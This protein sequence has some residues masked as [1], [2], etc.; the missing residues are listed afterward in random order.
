MK[1]KPKYTIE[2]LR[3]TGW[4]VAVLH[5][6]DV[7]HDNDGIQTKDAKMT[8]IIITNT[9]G[10]HAQGFSL[11]HP[12]DNYNRKLGNT[13]ALGRAMKNMLDGKHCT[14]PYFNNP[15]Q[16]TLTNK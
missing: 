3:K 8:H 16:T 6:S 4:K 11:S 5:T 2:A 9:K 7:R 15:Q 13:I 1:L 10:Q 12:L 14:M